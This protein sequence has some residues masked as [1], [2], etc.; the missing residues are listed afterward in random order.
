MKSCSR[1]SLSKTIRTVLNKVSLLILRNKRYLKNKTQQNSHAQNPT[2]HKKL[3]LCIFLYFLFII[4]TTNFYVGF[5]FL[6][7]YWYWL[8][9]LSLQL[10]GNCWQASAC[11]IHRECRRTYNKSMSWLYCCP[12]KM[13]YPGKFLRLLEFASL[14]YF[15]LWPF[16]EFSCMFLLLCSFS[17]TLR[18]FLHQE[19]KKPPEISRPFYCAQV[20]YA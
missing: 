4:Q 3:H 19:K 13:C 2:N 1:L 10:L 7:F 9:L 16:L 8:I 17:L 12:H 5:F 14:F 15:I 20:L 6:H 18:C 11:H